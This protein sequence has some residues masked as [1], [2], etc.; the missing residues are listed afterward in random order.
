MN[1][2]RFVFFWIYLL[3]LHNLKVENRVRV[4]ANPV[5]PQRLA[6]ILAERLEKLTTSDTFND[7]SLTINDEVDDDVDEVSILFY[8]EDEHEE[9][10]THCSC[11]NRLK[12]RK[13][14]CLCYKMKKKCSKM[15]HP[16]PIKS[17]CEN[18]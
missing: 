16:Q 11:A 13:Q 10:Q 2:P 14:S 1:G 3:E 4:D 7:D 18:K 5:N 8:G 6:N 17:K 12:C 9:E 15:C